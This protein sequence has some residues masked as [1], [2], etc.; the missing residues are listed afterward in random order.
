MNQDTTIKSNDVPKVSIG[1]PIYN[2]EYFLRKRLNSILSQSFT[3][4]ELIISDNASTDS[5]ASICK[6]YVEKDKR[7]RYFS[8]EKN[9]GIT[10]NFNFVLQKAKGEYFM[11]AAADDTISHDFL[12]KNIKVLESKANVVASISKIKPYDP[13][14]DRLQ[15]NEIDYKFRGFIK[16]LRKSFKQMEAYSIVGPYEKKVRFYLGK[17][18]CKVI[19]SVYRS[20]IIRKSIIHEPFLGN[21][22]AMILN[23]LRYGDLEVINETLMYEYEGGISA[24]GSINASHE[25]Y[26]GLRGIIFPWYPL[27]VWC[28]TNLGIKIF[29][30]NFDFFTRLNFEGA[31]SLVLD[32]LRL[33]IHRLT[34]K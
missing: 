9:M 7:I 17:S 27:T 29:L 8:Q 15:L 19:Y 22:W 13:T 18:T 6:E 26:H 4:F 31:I 24:T 33:S 20:E 14:S 30:K 3:N 32:M 11:W 16:K 25:Y 2:A 5:T 28:K 21:D 12:E 23:V 1:M 10:W 34:N